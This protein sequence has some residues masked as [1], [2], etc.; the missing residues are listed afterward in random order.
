MLLFVFTLQSC[1]I[2]PVCG[3]EHINWKKEE[4]DM[5]I[6]QNMVLLA[7]GSCVL[8]LLLS[9]PASAC[10]A[11][12]ARKKK[13]RKK[14]RMPLILVPSAVGILLVFVLRLFLPTDLADAAAVVL[15]AALTGF[16]LLYHAFSS[17]YGRTT[18]S[19]IETARTL[20]MSSR[21]ITR[22]LMMGR[23]R[24]EIA[25]GLLFAAARMFAEVLPTKGALSSMGT[26]GSVP[27]KLSRIFTDRMYWLSW[28]TAAVVLLAAG[29]LVSLIRKAA[30]HHRTKRTGNGTR[31]ADPKKTA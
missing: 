6:L 12:H 17:A 1:K 11:H 2:L 14:E 13:T 5:I 18:P 25:A 16:P 4:T 26:Q 20:G 31:S 7:A 27:E 15:S 28:C 21:M 8:T 19:E 22:K 23:S 3:L 10:A 30:D 24:P 9:F 29:L